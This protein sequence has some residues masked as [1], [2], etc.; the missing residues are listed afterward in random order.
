MQVH[1]E[2]WRDLDSGLSV[3]LGPPL[4]S[5]F[6]RSDERAAA[7]GIPESQTSI[8]SI[9]LIP[10][11]LIPAERLEKIFEEYTTYS[12]GHDRSGGGLGLAI[13]RMIVTQHEGIVWAK[14]SE[15]GPVFSFVLPLTPG[16][17]SNDNGNSIERFEYSEVRQ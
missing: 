10:A 2:G 17:V 1:P 13:C 7:A 12:G 16:A 11:R 6:N 9:S 4:R 8:V 3:L 14:N 15:V 5:E